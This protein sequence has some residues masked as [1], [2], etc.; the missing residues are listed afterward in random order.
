MNILEIDPKNKQ[1]IQKFLHLPFEL[2]KRTS[3]WVPPITSELR[4]IFNKDRNPFYRHGD[5]IFLLAEDR[6]EVIGRIAVLRNDNYLFYNQDRSAFFYMFECKND[7]I[8]AQLLLE[9]GCE[10]AKKQSLTSIQGPR[11]FS[12][13]DGL[14]MLVEGFDYRPAF[15]QPY[16]LAY[17]P[18]LIESAG[19]TSTG[20][21]V[22]G[23]LDSTF[24]FPEKVKAVAE[25][26]I[27]RRGLNIAVYKSKRD[28]K[29]LIPDLK[30]LYNDSFNES[31]GNIPLS[32]DD[33]KSLAD[34]MMWFADPRLIKIVLKAD[35]PIGF[36]MAY[37]DISAAIQKTKGR[38]LPF[39]WLS[40]MIEMKR[41]Q[42]ININGSGMMEGYRGSGGTA[43]LFNEM[44]KSVSESKYRFA[45]I[46]QIGTENEN[47]LR[48]MSNF[49]IQFYKK[50]RLYLKTLV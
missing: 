17:Y 29:K 34:Q 6:G 21:L 19:F 12:V 18:N 50:H 16:N 4:G 43:I 14:G 25:I 11:G 9:E 48:E 39:G 41:T 23:Y 1:H 8:A 33:V 5:A 36:L 35:K 2:Y 31:D 44:Y 10:W 7:P 46:V 38:I 32:D 45:D 26:A 24:D 30:N 3:Q 42:W 20:E 37:P 28:I 13:F 15:G 40:M 22:S 47:M 27:R 49:G